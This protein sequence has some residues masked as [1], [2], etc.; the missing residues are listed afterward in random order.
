MPRL[1]YTGRKKIFRH[2]ISITVFDNNGIL[3][4]DADIK[5]DHYRLP[6]NAE[7]YVEAY[8]QAVWMRFP[9]GTIKNLKKPE[10]RR[11]FEFDSL[12]GILFRVKITQSDGMHGKLFALADRIR[13]RK[14]E[15]GD[16]K[17][18]DGILPVKSQEMD[19][20]WRID[21]SD[22]RPVLLISKQ[23]G[24]KDAIC[25]S[26]EFISLVYPAAF[27]EILCRLLIDPPD[28]SDDM[29]NWRCQWKEFIKI[30]P[31]IDDLPDH[32]EENQHEEWLDEAVDAFSRAQNVLNI[33][34]TYWQGNE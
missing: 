20:L 32:S 17:K 26:K 8:R 14:P 19:C 21:F 7:I 15:E 10:N 2:D 34:T 30:L 13:P 27:R 25:R 33:F 18:P 6:E 16:A 12:D 24:S 11:L 29:D 9:Y 28:D 31:G 3:S 5:T 22:D 1:N 4:F 23:A